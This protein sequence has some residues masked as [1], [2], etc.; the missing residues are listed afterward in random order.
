MK[1]IEFG[2]VSLWLIIICAAI[3]ALGVLSTVNEGSTMTAYM[4]AFNVLSIVIA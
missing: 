2:R 1:K 4:N 3:C